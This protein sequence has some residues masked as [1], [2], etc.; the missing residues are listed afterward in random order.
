MLTQNLAG[1]LRTL[2][3][4]L[5][6]SIISFAVQILNYPLHNYICRDCLKFFKYCDELPKCAC[7]CFCILMAAS[8]FLEALFFMSVLTGRHIHL[9]EIESICLRPF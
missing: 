2:I 6:H 5:S 4:R 8:V 7:T 3:P 9:G 1:H